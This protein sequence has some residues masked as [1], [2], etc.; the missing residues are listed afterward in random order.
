MAGEFGAWTPIGAVADGSGYEVAWKDPGPDQYTVW[1]IDSNGNYISAMPSAQYRATAARWNRWRPA[2]TRTSTATG[3]SALP[4]T[5]IQTDG[6][7]SLVRSGTNYFLDPVGGGTGPELKYR[8]RRSV[9][10]GEFGAWTPIGAVQTGSGYEVAWKDAGRQT[11]T[12]SGTPTAAATTRAMPSAQY[13]AA[14]PHW[15]LGDQLPSG[16][17]RRRGDRSLRPAQYHSADQQPPSRRDR[18]GYDWDWCHARTC[19]R[20]LCVGH[21]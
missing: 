4:T 1:N 2:S 6:S 15:N 11:S 10:A 7:T 21:I 20:Q 5:V 16:P 3:R 9:T 19:C 17:Q 14:A 8:R 18:C 13:L 12:R